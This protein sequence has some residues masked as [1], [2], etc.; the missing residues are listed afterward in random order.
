MRPAEFREHVGVHWTREAPSRTVGT[1]SRRGGLTAKLRIRLISTRD[2]KIHP[3]VSSNN[4]AMRW[5]TSPPTSLRLS[6]YL[7]STSME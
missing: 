4:F 5:M 7:M 6:S 1:Q 3:L 2:T